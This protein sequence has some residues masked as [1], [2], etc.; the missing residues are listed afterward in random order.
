[1]SASISPAGWQLT[2]LLVLGLLLGLA[3]WTD[4]RQRRIPNLLVL[5]ALSLGLLLNGSGPLAEDGRGGIFSPVPGALGAAGA[6]LGAL[7]A[8]ALFL[9]LYLLRATGAGD[10][11]L[12]AGIGSFL[13]PAGAVN[14][15]LFVLLCGGLLAIVRMLWTG[16]SRR[17]MANVGAVLGAGGRFDPATQ[18]A[19]RMPYAVAIAVGVLAYG[20]WIFSGHRPI[21]DF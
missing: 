1:M 2:A 7:A 19:D 21:L 20:A 13:G 12:M 8:F 15:V 14:L 4:I 3:V 18:S 5:V 17:V 16:S 10:V 9:P 11:K 6:A